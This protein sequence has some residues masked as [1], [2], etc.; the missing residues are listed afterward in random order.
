M[1]DFDV[2]KDSEGK[3]Y[4]IFD[5]SELYDDSQMG[6]KFEDFEVLSQLGKGGFGAVFKVRSKINNKVYAIKRV[7]LEKLR[8]QIEDDGG[9]AERAIQLTKEEASVLEKYNHPHILKFYKKFEDEN[10]IYI[11]TEYVDNGDINGFIEAHK[12][13]NKHISEEVLWSIFLQCMSGL[14]EVHSKDVIHRDIKPSN[15]LM[16]NNMIVKLADFGISALM[17]NNEKHNTIVGTDGYKTREIFMGEDYDSKVDVYAMGCS[18]F[19]MCYFHIP[20]IFRCKMINGKYEFIYEK[21]EEKEDKYIDGLYSKQLLYIIHLMLEEDPNKR[22]TSQ[23]ILDIIKEEYSKKYSKNSSI[24]SMVRC[25]Y[26]IT[27]LRDYF[28]DMENDKIAGKPITKA[29]IDCLHITEDR[30][31]LSDWSKFIE[32]FRE[33][34]YSENLRLE[35]KGEI[36]PRYAFAFLIKVFHKELNKGQNKNNQNNY[37]IVS[38]EEKSKT[39]KIEVMLNYINDFYSKYNSRISKDF[40]GINKITKFCNSCKL[41]TFSFNTYFFITFNLEDILKRYN[42]IAELNLLEQLINQKTSQTE[43]PLYCSKCLN[44]TIH[45]TFKELYSLPN[46]LVISIQRGITYAYK[47]PVKI[48]KTLDL[49]D[50]VE[51][52]YSKK[53]YNLV[54]LLGRDEDKDY[55]FAIIN[56]GNVWHLCRETQIIKLDEKSTNFNYYGDILMLFYI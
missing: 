41:R 22:K 25:L 1:S 50:I 14:A 29:Y 21:V 16:D 33:T 39:N 12:E 56:V 43:K 36:E 30:E 31:T 53:K 51:F 37:L 55:F 2:I 5:S 20:K 46:L 34:L 44:K 48:D 28:K 40:S 38:G 35:V 27:P 24:D 49:T 54:S 52:E 10:N 9:D 42:N 15:L 8:K 4:L 45:S 32:L 19:Q 23:E 13:F 6:D 18:F 7:N 26:S 17:E 3:E 47:T 11:V